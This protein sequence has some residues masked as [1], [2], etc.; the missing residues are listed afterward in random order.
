MSYE[1]RSSDHE[2]FSQ[3]VFMKP[4][5]P[6]LKKTINFEDEREELLRLLPETD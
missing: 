4:Q 5:V 6:S 3:L 2:T 1:E